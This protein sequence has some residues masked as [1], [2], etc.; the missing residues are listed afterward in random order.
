MGYLKYLLSAA[1]LLATAACFQNCLPEDPATL[2]PIT[3]EGKNTIGCRANGSLVLPMYNRGPGYF[4]RVEHFND[5]VAISFGIDGKSSG[6]L[7]YLYAAPTIQTDVDYNLKVDRYCLEYYSRDCFEYQTNVKDGTIRF[8]RFDQ[9][10]RIMSGIFN[11]TLQAGECPQEVAIT[12]GR[13]D[14]RY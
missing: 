5:T 7:V 14:L 9:T 1:V 12:D 3:T 4:S 11:Y 6:I 8:L 13:F 10:N 2:P